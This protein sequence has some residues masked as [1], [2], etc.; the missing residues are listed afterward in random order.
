MF[1][2]RPDEEKNS[3]DMANLMVQES[4]SHKIEHVYPILAIAIVIDGTDLRMHNAATGI[5][6]LF[7]RIELTQ[8]KEIVLA[9]ETG[10]SGLHE[11]EIE[12]M[13][14]EEILVVPVLAVE[15]GGDIG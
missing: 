13:G 2:S 14:G 15:A 10:G 12:F 8:V 3:H 11:G 4:R 1:K 5:G 6:D 7:P 9:N